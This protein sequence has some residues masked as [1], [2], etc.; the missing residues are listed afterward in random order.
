MLA[1]ARQKAL[2]S[3]GGGEREAELRLSRTVLLQTQGD[4]ERWHS[5]PLHPFVFP[6][7]EKQKQTLGGR[8]GAM[9][10]VEGQREKRRDEKKAEWRHKLF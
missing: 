5:I 4:D 7:L 1:A 8:D 6:A 10:L 9:A 3:R 2:R